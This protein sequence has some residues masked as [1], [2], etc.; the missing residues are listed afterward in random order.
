MTTSK[1]SQT[2]APDEAMA[3]DEL[4][5][6]WCWS[7]AGNLVRI[8]SG[9]FIK[10]SEYAGKPDAPYP[11]AGAGGIIGRTHRFNF[12]APVMVLGRVGAAGTLNIYARDVW[13]TDNAL[14]IIAAAPIFDWLR[15]FFMTVNWSDLK[16][17]S[18]QPLI[19]Q[20]IVKELVLPF[21]P[22]AEQ[23]RIVAKVE[24]LLAEVNRVRARLEKV[25]KLLKAF[26][27]SVLAAACSGRL[28][29]DWRKNNPVGDPATRLLP[30]IRAQRKARIEEAGLTQYKEPLQPD[31]TLLP[32]IP[33]QWEIASM[34]HLVCHVT[35]GSRGWARYYANSGPYFIRAENIN[36]DTLSLD[37]MAHVQPPANAEGRRTRIERNDLLVMITGAN[38]TKSALVE[39]A[40]DE[41]YVSQHVA[42]LRPVDPCLGRYLYLWTISPHHG[43]AKLLKH[44]YG[45]GKPGLNLNNIKEMA[46]A[47][48]P[49]DEQNEIVRRVEALFALADMIETQVES[50]TKRAEKIMQASLAKAFRGE[51]VP[52]E[53]ELA[54]RES[55]AYEPAS[56]LLERI[57]SESNLK[58]AD[59]TCDTPARRHPIRAV[60]DKALPIEREGRLC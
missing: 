6:G 18:S 25:P 43:R 23:K 21:P 30:S 29:E 14:V 48:P 49:L 2:E 26:R 28:T 22:L 59:A 55:R 54:R 3:S 9:E 34:D 1:L 13:V 56:V 33:D 36:A 15:L 60:I 38:V 41:A 58:A 40:L 20:G 39:T 8:T 51:L 57:K 35:S 4:P 16:S 17:G 7:T 11:V 44:A 31:E 24:V 52:T 46:V 19:T 50:A 37:G 53:A 12:S 5:E 45:A 27:Q 42:L 47:L 32:E 10:R